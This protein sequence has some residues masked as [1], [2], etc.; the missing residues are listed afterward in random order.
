ME[1]ED[2]GIEAEDIGME[3]GIGDGTAADGGDHVWSLVPLSGVGI[4]MGIPLMDTLRMGIPHMDTPRI[5]RP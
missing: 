2:I 1:A 3:A 5:H 4:P